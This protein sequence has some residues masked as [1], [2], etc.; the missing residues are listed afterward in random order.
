MDNAESELAAEVEALSEKLASLQD[1]VRE[2]VE[3]LGHEG[4]DADALRDAVGQ[5]ERLLDGKDHDG[6]FTGLAE[7]LRLALAPAPPCEVSPEQRRAAMLSLISERAVF[8]R[9]YSDG[10]WAPDG[11]GYA[12]CA[13]L[14]GLQLPDYRGYKSLGECPQDHSHTEPAIETLSRFTVQDDTPLALVLDELVRLRQK[15]E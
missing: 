13:L 5:I 10:L 12:P 4:A 6:A 14:A 3:L 11:R 9:R 2:V 1:V 7:K 8:V 15:E